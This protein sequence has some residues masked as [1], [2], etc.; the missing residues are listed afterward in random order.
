[1]IIDIHTHLFGKGWL[2]RKFFHGIARFITHEFAKQG[3][4]QT[5]EEVGDSLVEGSDDPLAE[6]LLAEMDEAGIDQSVMLPVDFGL[7]LGEP[8]VSIREVNRNMAQLAQKYPDRLIAFAGVDPRRKDALELFCDCIEA[9]GMKGLKLHPCAGFYPNQTEVYALLEKASQWNIPVIIHSGSMM[10][11]LRSK[12]SQAV[13]FDDLGV[14]FPDLPIIAAHAGGSFGYPQML[15]V[16]NTKLN[17]MVDI[18]AW[19]IMALR[20][21]PLF[22]AALRNIMD[23][24]E[25]ERVFFGSDSPSFRSIMSSKDWVELLKK[26]PENAPDGVVFKKEEIALLMGGNARRILNI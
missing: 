5:N 3:I 20:N 15:S 13:Y 8:E 25:P 7:A 4:Q 10:V 14:D 6:S 24:S 22:C 9:W 11:P 17:I 18:S 16:M 2:P 1:M 19:Q 23:F 12:Y 26:L 21:Y